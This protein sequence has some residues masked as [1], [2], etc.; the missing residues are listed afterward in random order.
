MKPIVI[1]LMF[2]AL[3]SA[4]CAA[5]HPEQ[6]LGKA[7]RADDATGQYQGTG[8]SRG[9]VSR[10]SDARGRS[11]GTAIRKADVWTSL[12]ATSITELT[13]SLGVKT[14]LVES[15]K[16]FQ[17][18]QSIRVYSTAN[19]AVVWMSATITAYNCS[20]GVLSVN[21]SN[22]SGSGTF[23]SWG[24]VVSSTYTSLRRH[25]LEGQQSIAISDGV[26]HY[27]ING[28]VCLSN[29]HLLA[30]VRVNHTHGASY[31]SPL[32]IIESED[33]GNTWKNERTIAS[34]DGWDI[35]PSC[36]AV[37][38]DGRIGIMYSRR[39]ASNTYV[40]DFIYSDDDGDTWTLVD[41]VLPTGGIHLYGP[42]LEYPESVGGDDD[43]GFAVFGYRGAIGVKAAVTTDN[44]LTWTLEDS[45][46]LPGLGFTEST[47]VRIPGQDKWLMFLRNDATK[48]KPLYISKSSDL[49]TW[50]TPVA[51][52]FIAGKNPPFAIIDSTGQLFLYIF[53]RDFGLPAGGNENTVMMLEDDPNYIY[54]NLKFSNTKARPVMSIPERGLG[55]IYT[56][57]DGTDLYWGFTCQ[58]ISSGT[59]SWT[60][61]PASICIGSTRTII[62]MG[63]TGVE[64]SIAGENMI[65]NPIFNWWTRGSRFTGITSETNVADGWKLF[66]SGSTMSAERVELDGDVSM[67][68]PFNPRY[69]M[70]VTSTSGDNHG[71][72]Q[73]IYDREKFELLCGN[74]VGV[75]LWGYGVPPT[76]GLKLR[77]CY[78]DGGSPDNTTFIASKVTS[79]STG[80]WYMDGV[81]QLPTLDKVK[82]GT[83]PFI[84]VGPSIGADTTGTWDTIFC[85]MK[86]EVGGITK[87][88]TDDPVKDKIICQQYLR[89]VSFSSLESVGYIY[90]MPASTATML[91]NTPAMIQPPSIVTTGLDTA[92]I[93]SYASSVIGGTIT[94]IYPCG[95][96]GVRVEMNGSFTSGTVYVG[97]VVSG[98]IFSFILDAE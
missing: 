69:G 20:T 64:R 48:G 65:R 41:D 98:K 53:F 60:G 50:T 62:P 93:E 38:G 45:G 61:F 73:Y 51:S 67:L 52:K 32:N 72:Y 49:T 43:T 79:F 36:A 56:A 1:I 34:F 91:V 39:N 11:Q 96:T 2:L 90:G 35:A 19:P 31:G 47:V 66:P 88:G 71:L 10:M 25:P 74:S 80:V 3:S 6:N 26:S 54:D 77:I 81:F 40:N 83:G 46:I 21:V 85:G 12:A 27:W 78:G 95:S 22:T 42:M 23:S 76:G 13:V 44:G 37:M 29:G 8:V 17:V 86:V 16:H 94:N 14:L 57:T 33:G 55:Y 4:A 68:F 97:R 63:I 58:E 24:L 7:F 70:R 75:Q 28:L 30:V 18:G 82:V 87:F 59:P 84:S 5:S 92:A 9:N 89:K 15:G